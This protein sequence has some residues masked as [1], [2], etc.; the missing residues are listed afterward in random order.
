MLARAVLGDPYRP[1]RGALLSTD[2][3]RA[4]RSCGACIMKKDARGEAVFRL[5]GTRFCATYGRELKGFAFASL[6]KEKDQRMIHRLAYGA[7]DAK[8][9]VVISYRGM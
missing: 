9:V 1:S 2:G 7:F 6:W 8:S 3:T 5:A 4:G